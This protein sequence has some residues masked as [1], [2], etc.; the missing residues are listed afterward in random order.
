[1]GGTYICLHKATVWRSTCKNFKNR[2]KAVT[3]S[4][5]P[6]RRKTKSEKLKNGTSRGLEVLEEIPEI[7][8]SRPG[9]RNRQRKP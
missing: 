2:L 9:L 4:L 5:S 1:V 3:Q 6:P 7:L 8:E